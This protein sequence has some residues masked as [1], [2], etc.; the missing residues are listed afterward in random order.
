MRAPLVVLLEHAIERGGVK[1]GA[2]AAAFVQS[3]AAATEALGHELGEGEHLTA[4]LQEYAAFWRV[5]ER[6]AWNELHR[7]R[8]VF[9]AEQSPARLARLLADARDSRPLVAALRAA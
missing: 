4:A 5:S 9:P 2:Q 3:W 6:T 7:F 1:R 8:G